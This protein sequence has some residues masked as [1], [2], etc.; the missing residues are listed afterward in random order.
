MAGLAGRSGALS[1]PPRT[2]N[3][4]G[5][6]VVSL[7]DVFGSLVPAPAAAALF[8]AE[9]YRAAYLER[10]PW[11]RWP[12]AHY[13]AFGARRG[14]RPNPFFDPDY[15]RAR[16][17]EAGIALRG[18]PLG[19]YLRHGAERAE[20]PSPEFDPAWYR[21]RYGAVGEA[22]HPLRHFL[23]HGIAEGRDPAPYIDLR[24]WMSAAGATPETASVLLMRQIAR[25]GR[26][27]GDGVDYGFRDL[28]RRQAAFR[29][30]LDWRLLR[31]AAR[32]L[33]PNLVYVQTAP[34]VRRDFA[35]PER[36]FDLLLNYYADPGPVPDSPC[37][38]AIV[39]R[40]TKMTAV[41]AILRRDP[42]L[43]LA[44]ERVLF[45]DDD[46]EITAADLDRFFA[47]MRDRDLVL[48]Q[49]LLTLD[50][51]CAWPIFR[52][53]AHRG[54]VVP[55]NTVEV[56][57][58]A[59][60][61]EA[62]ER[63]AWTFGEAISGFGV[64][65]L[66]GQTWPEAQA[67]GRIAI[68]GQVCARHRRAIDQ[69]DGAFYRFLAEHGIE[70]KQE[71]WRIMHRH[72]V[73]LEFA[74]LPAP[75]AGEPDRRRAD[76]LLP[77]PAL[78]RP[79]DAPRLSLAAVAMVRNEADILPDFLAHCAALFDRLI[80]M[81]HRSTDGSGEILRVAQARGGLDMEILGSGVRGYYQASITNFLVRRALS[82]GADWVL[83]LDADEFVDVPDR[84]ALEALL[85]SQPEGA[86][87]FRWRNLAPDRPGRWERFEVVGDYWHRSAP[88][89]WGKVALSRRFAERYPR[90]WLRLGN[91][92]VLPEPGAPQ[93]VPLPEAG[94]YLHIPIRSVERLTAKLEGGIAAYRARE[95]RG[96][97]GSHWS[98][99]LAK[100]QAGCAGECDLRDA[101]LGY[102]DAARGVEGADPGPVV[103]RHVAP[104]M[105]ELRLDLAVPAAD[106]VRR[107]ERSVVWQ[108]LK[109]EDDAAVTVTLENSELVLTPRILRPDGAP[110]PE[111]FQALA[112]EPPPARP[113][114]QALVS[115][116][117]AAFTPIETVVPS[118]W[119]RHAP[120]LFS[121]FA[122]LRPRRYVELGTHFG[123][124]FFAA[125]Q[126]ARQFATET[127]CVAI[128]T[129]RGDQHVGSYGDDV[130]AQFCELF[131]TRH[132][133]AGYLIRARFEDAVRCFE[134][135]SIDLLHID[136]VHT[137][138]AV[139]ADFETW[140]PKLSRRGVIL[141]HDTTVYEGDFGVWRLWE[142]ISREYP[143]VNL[144]HCH[145]LGVLYVGD[146]DGN[147]L[148]ELMSRFAPGSEGATLLN[149]LY[150]GVGALS[151]AAASAREPQRADPPCAV[152]P[153][154]LHEAQARIA[155]LEAE[156]VAQRRQVEALLASTS[157]RVTAPLRAVRL[158][159]GRLGSGRAAGR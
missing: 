25:H 2:E 126:A 52:D 148:A 32:P 22:V 81:D 64:D 46:I 28:E 17:A 141:F 44:Y 4:S 54:R 137:Y 138:E 107:R 132:P 159:L 129:W 87:V 110:G 102:G 62:L 106:E 15:Y 121:L 42:E 143:A 155:Q 7:Q 111:R 112:A 70:P 103:R 142:R 16:L 14:L 134:G 34:G 6:T 65:L 12:F 116:L 21:R 9:A 91:H 24:R 10:S 80:V 151:V 47:I 128:D 122:L 72:N 40:G 13:L 5:R 76:A 45:L 97:E 120:L 67:A 140:R 83:P 92:D 71:L 35:V 48:A 153:E 75:A 73:T 154:R 66:W 119:S 26:L 147:G 3:S 156:L 79:D 43:L 69:V 29:A 33:R 115:A 49:P 109:V 96:P 136:G 145:G 149:C 114:H 23:A 38:H 58:P 127:E 37:E 88:S 152:A 90:F 118:S 101:A 57:M 150:R 139:L 108:H 59:F 39:Q 20:P 1:S 60:S 125:C 11:R 51:D 50:S 94:E 158:M 61:R 86:C 117:E 95:K 113:D 123:F 63:Q 135:G 98:D 100:L 19:F 85:A 27:Q 36:S 144:L 99:L 30:G 89:P 74:P 82:A 104:P 41:D 84:R 146:E 93:P 130:F 55:V 53:P 78:P 157:W 31:R 124:S 68:I 18:C 56:M 131:R 77:R 105:R 8:D 133:A